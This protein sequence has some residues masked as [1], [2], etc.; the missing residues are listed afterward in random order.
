MPNDFI[1]LSYIFLSFWWLSVGVWYVGEAYPPGDAF[2]ILYKSNG[3]FWL[4]SLYF[5][6][7][8]SK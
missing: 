1:I 6:F 2:K 4:I 3:L 8:N 5:L 7:G